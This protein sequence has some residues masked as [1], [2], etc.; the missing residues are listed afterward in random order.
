MIRPA[1]VQDAKEIAH[2]HIQTWR[3][4]YNGIIPQAHLQSLSIDERTEHWR[5]RL[6]KYPERTLVAQEDGKVVGWVF[7]GPG[8]DD[9]AQGRGE[10]Y[11]FYIHPDRWRCGFGRGLIKG[12]EQHLWKRGFGAITL[13]VLEDNQRAKKFYA[14]VGFYYDGTRK[15]ITIGGEELWELRYVKDIEA[16]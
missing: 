16:C 6:S 5:E 11:G 10:I 4:A 8:R 15:Q 12:V 3:A 1:T 14:K 2:I 13:W 7:L 9:D